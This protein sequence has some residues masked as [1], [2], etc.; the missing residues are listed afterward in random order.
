MT[1]TQPQQRP[2][3]PSV[4]IQKGYCRFDS[5]PEVPFSIITDNHQGIVFNR[6][7]Q[8]FFRTGT[9]STE[10]VG[11]N[12]KFGSDEPAKIIRAEN[13]NIVLSAPKGTV[14]IIAANIKLVSSNP[15]GGQ[16]ILDSTGIIQV[17][18]PST[19]VQG[20]NFS[21]AAAQG[22]SI[23]GGT[24]ATN[25]VIANDQTTATDEAKASFFGQ[26]LAGIKRFSNF[27]TS[28]CGV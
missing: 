16:I 17:T 12:I 4:V 20:D 14:E 7:G 11:Q 3:E 24:V 13:G 10:V 22:A 6:D 27:F 9:N 19:N 8:S 15:L 26:I 23:G 1:T 25:G 5:N 18:A 21:V 2:C 28:I